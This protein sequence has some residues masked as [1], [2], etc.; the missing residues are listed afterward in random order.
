MVKGKS[1]A[2]LRIARTLIRSKAYFAHALPLYNL[3]GHWFFKGE[4]TRA[5]DDRQPDRLRAAPMQSH[6]DEPTCRLRLFASQAPTMS[7][8]AELQRAQA[9]LGP[10]RHQIYHPP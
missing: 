10:A 1:L 6:T 4:R 8:Q 3:D 9:M 2:V 7:A 5:I